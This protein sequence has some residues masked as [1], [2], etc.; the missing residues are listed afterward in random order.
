MV[1]L[2][3]VYRKEESQNA[4]NFHKNFIEYKIKHVKTLYYT[5]FTFFLLRYIYISL[6]V[7]KYSKK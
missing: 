3:L 2:R 7:C 4:I 5:V 6:C 1:R